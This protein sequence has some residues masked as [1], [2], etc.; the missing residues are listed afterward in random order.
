MAK[1]KDRTP[2]KD[3]RS[4]AFQLRINP[5]LHQQLKTLTDHDNVT[6]S[7]WLKELARDELRRRGIEPAG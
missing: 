2:K 7:C 3:G 4:G 6:L 1:L 5:Q